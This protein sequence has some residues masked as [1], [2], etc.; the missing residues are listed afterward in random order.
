LALSI[1]AQ[2]ATSVLMSPVELGKD[3]PNREVAVLVGLTSYTL[4]LWK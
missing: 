4:L 1:R 3:D 2:S